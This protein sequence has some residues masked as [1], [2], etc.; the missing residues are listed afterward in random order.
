MFDKIKRSANAAAISFLVVSP[1][2]LHAQEL[3]DE[4]ASAYD[5]QTG[6]FERLKSTIQRSLTAEEIKRFDSAFLALSGNYGAD[7]L[8]PCASIQVLAHA[9][10]LEG[11]RKDG[12][13]GILTFCT[14]NMWLA[15]QVATSFFLMVSAG[16]LDAEPPIAVLKE[17][18]Q[19]QGRNN[20]L[21]NLTGSSPGPCAAVYVAYLALRYGALNHCRGP[22]GSSVTYDEAV[23][24]LIK[25]INRNFLHLGVKPD[26]LFPTSFP[27]MA[28]GLQD[29]DYIFQ[30]AIFD[31]TALHEAGHLVKGHH[32]MGGGTVDVE[33]QREAEA[34]AF[35]Q[36]W[37]PER[38]E[39]TSIAE[40]AVAGY[41]LYASGHQNLAK[42]GNE[43]LA[44]QRL[45]DALSPCQMIKRLRHEQDGSEL[46][47]SILALM[48]KTYNKSCP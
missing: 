4:A 48:T 23:S 27:A 41:S 44:T 8:D 22:S 12:L 19:D 7:H 33:F 42:I 6:T 37:N 26:A 15:A 38:K 36:R 40:I 34:D 31:L 2:F 1:I 9:S 13:D 5:G 30:L 11:Q 3:K 10:K 35:I 45:T 28:R 43:T 29:L 20:A 46:G 18:L 24:F 16:E 25:R 17:L 47:K 14:K 39:L 32:R 21:I